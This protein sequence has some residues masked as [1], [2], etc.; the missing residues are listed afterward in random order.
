MLWVMYICCFVILQSVA[1]DWVEKYQ[2]EPYPAMGELIQFFF[3]FSGC[4][5]QLN[6]ESFDDMDAAIT[7]EELALPENFPEVHTYVHTFV[8]YVPT[9]CI[10]SIC[11]YVYFYLRGEP[12][13]LKFYDWVFRAF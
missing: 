1:S 6:Y 2:E 12:L 9:T 8:L 3:N 5:E 4:T 11:T 13:L 10:Y 7:T